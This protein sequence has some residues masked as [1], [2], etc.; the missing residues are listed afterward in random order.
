MICRTF[1]RIQSPLGIQRVSSDRLPLAPTPTSPVVL[2]QLLKEIRPKEKAVN[3]HSKRNDMMDLEEGIATCEPWNRL[4]LRVSARNSF[5]TNMNVW[6]TLLR[7]SILVNHIF[8]LPLMEWTI[9]HVFT[10][11]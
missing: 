3:R 5:L 4:V 2:S 11:T 7:I 8:E 6:R 9:R 10:S 1:L